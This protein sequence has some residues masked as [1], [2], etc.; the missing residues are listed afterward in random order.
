MCA[1]S[2]V[3]GVGPVVALKQTF[4]EPVD[5]LVACQISFSINSSATH[6]PRRGA[7]NRRDELSPLSFDHLMPYSPT[8]LPMTSPNDS[9]RSPLN[10]LS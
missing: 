4:S 7:D 9:Q 3:P 8:S 5:T 10:F 2:T 6:T 1:G